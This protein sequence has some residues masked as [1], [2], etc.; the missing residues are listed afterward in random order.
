MKESENQKDLFL[1][2]LFR[3]AEV[4]GDLNITEKV[5]QEIKEIPVSAPVAYEPPISKRGWIIVGTFFF[6]LFIY[7][8]LMDSSFTVTLPSFSFSASVFFERLG[9]SFSFDW[10]IP[11]LPSLS[12]PYLSVL[13][14]FILVGMYFMAS[15]WRGRKI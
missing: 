11:Q 14:A 5:M 3:E 2:S 15:Y 12:G 6:S 13:F 4:K 7:A 9:N 1:K 8:L 10:S